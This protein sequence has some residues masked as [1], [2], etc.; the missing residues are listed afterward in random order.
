M[1][2]PRT[3]D[4]IPFYGARDRALFEIER[5]C[6]DRDGVI[7]RHL[8]DLLPDGV[9]LDVGAGDGFTAERI[10][11]SRRR[12]VAAEP[13]RGMTEASRLLPWVRALAQALPFRPAAFDGAHATFAYFFPAIGHGEEGLLEIDRVLRPRAP[14][15]FVDSAGDDELDSLRNPGDVNRGESIASPRDWWHERGFRSTVIATSF[16]FRTIEDAQ[17]LLGFFFGEV[18]R[19]SARLEVGFDAV[20]YLREAPGESSS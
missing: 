9:V 14:F 11:G 2:W 5:R 19:D 20:A 8:D 4:W 3:S 12:V 6:M 1:S 18:G 17:K 16:R 13:A 15:V 7:L 10:T